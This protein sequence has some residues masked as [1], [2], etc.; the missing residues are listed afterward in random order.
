MSNTQAICNSF[1]T[2][3]LNGIHAFAAS[4]IRAATTKD[5]FKIALYKIGATMNKSTT[6]YGATNEVET[7]GDYAAGGAA[8]TNANAPTI[9]TDVAI[10][11]PSASITFTGVTFSSFDCALLY[12]S[13]QGN[14]AVAVYTFGTYQITSGNFTIT[15]PANAAATALLQLA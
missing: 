3:I 5:S 4:V 8:V 6:A 7:S 14:K 2:E 12:N 11:T 1:K 13:T 15:M 10:W 9:D